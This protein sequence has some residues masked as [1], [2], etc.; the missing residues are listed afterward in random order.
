M[1]RLITRV[2][3]PNYL[4]LYSDEILDEQVLLALFVWDFEKNI[5]FSV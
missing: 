3:G 5:F 4:Y 1:M 2:F